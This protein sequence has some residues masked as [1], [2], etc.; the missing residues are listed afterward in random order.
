MPNNP[1][2]PMRNPWDGDDTKDPRDPEL[3]DPFGGDIAAPA[4]SKPATKPAKAPVKRPAPAK[5]PA[6][7]TPR[8]RA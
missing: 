7:R 2:P 4:P 5:A 1:E 8:K 6:K 3:K